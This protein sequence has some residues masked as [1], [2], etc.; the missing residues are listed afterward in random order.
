[1]NIHCKIHAIN[2]I[3][4]PQ[5]DYKNSLSREDFKHI[6]LSKLIPIL[7]DNGFEY[8]DL[9]PSHGLSRKCTGVNLLSRKFYSNGIV[10]MCSLYNNT[11]KNIMNHVDNEYKW[12]HLPD[13]PTKCIHCY[14]YPYCVVYDHVSA[15]M[16]NILIK[17]LK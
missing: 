15:V 16:E 17:N 8:S 12:N 7:H 3:N 11:N 1:M 4:Y 10:T 5:C 9:L 14:D 2:T 13:L 6:W